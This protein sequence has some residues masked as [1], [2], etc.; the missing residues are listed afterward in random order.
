[1]HNVSAAECTIRM[2]K[3]GAHFVGI[4]CYFDPFVSLECSSTLHPP[5][6]TRWDIHRIARKAYDLGVRYVGGC[7]GFQPYHIRAVAEE[8]EP[9]RGTK[10]AGSENHMP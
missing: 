2:T 4:N 1:M 6:S 3:A 7:F 5:P 9:E 8:L 10:A